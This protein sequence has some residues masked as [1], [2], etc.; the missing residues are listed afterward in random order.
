MMKKLSDKLPGPGQALAEAAFNAPGLSRSMPDGE[1][2][3][4]LLA[5]RS[6]AGQ[7]IEQDSQGM[8]SRIAQ[9]QSRTAQ[10]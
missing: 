6:R 1:V 5:F 7:L 10:K 8:Q 9:E 3:L 2:G 4:R